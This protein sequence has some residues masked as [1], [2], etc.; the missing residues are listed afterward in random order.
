MIRQ[1]APS[2]ANVLITGEKR[3]RQ[4]PGRAGAAFA[5]ASCCQVDDHSQHGR[6]LRKRFLKANCS[7]T[8][9]A[10]LP[11]QK[12]I[13]PADLSWPTK[14]LCSWTKSQIFAQPAGQAFTRYR[15]WRF[16]RV[17]SSKTLARE[18]TAFSATN[19]S[20]HDEVASGRFRQ[21]LLFRL[22]TIEIRLPSLRD[23]QEDIM[24][25]ANHFLRQVTQRY[26]KQISGFDE[27]A[28]EQLLRHPFPGNVR[29]LDH[30]IERAVLMTRG[31]QIKASDLGLTTGAGDSRSL[32]A[33]S[34]EE[35]EAFLI[36]K[37]SRETMGTRGKPRSARF[38]SECILPTASAIW[39]LIVSNC[40]FPSDERTSKGRRRLSYENRLTWLALGAAVPGAV[41]ALI[42]LWSGDYSAKVQWTLT[43][44]IVCCFLG[45]IS[46]AREHLVRR[47]KR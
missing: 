18:C 16:E 38:E 45:F 17:G 25:L 1:V 13:V 21:D 37:A 15:N 7:V 32:E 20:L 2:D 42:I 34:L 9:K 12:P 44:L 41:I 23:R 11:M 8:S 35:V 39:T 14:A 22:N 6:S 4:R 10:R 47:C 31:P 33:M 24:P 43:L 19:A 36:K 46:S 27:T 40:G 28:R 29:E 30:V 26:R 3:D 5:F